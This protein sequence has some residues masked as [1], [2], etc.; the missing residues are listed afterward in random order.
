VPHQD[1]ARLSTMLYKASTH[2]EFIRGNMTRNPYSTAPITSVHVKIKICKDLDHQ[3]LIK[4][5]NGM[6]LLVHNNIININLR[7]KLVYEQVWQVLSNDV[8]PRPNTPMLVEYRLQ[9]LDGDGTEEIF[10]M[11]THLRLS[12]KKNI[13]SHL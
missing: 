1:R 2:E 12:L 3:A 10:P 13:K 9:G 11:R 5:D 6:E 7:K 4:D 8:I